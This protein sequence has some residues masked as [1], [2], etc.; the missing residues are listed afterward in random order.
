MST[1]KTAYENA[2]RSLILYHP[3]PNAPIYE[4]AIDAYVNELEKQ[5]IELEIEIKKLKKL[6]E[7]QE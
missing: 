4:A 3:G 7:E 5:I 1:P 6:V 2:L